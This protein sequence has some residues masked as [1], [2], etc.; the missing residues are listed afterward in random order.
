MTLL[1]L[2][3]VSAALGEAAYGLAGVAA[4]FFFVAAVGSGVKWWGRLNFRTSVSHEEIEVR[5]Y[6]TR[7]IPWAEVKGF[8]IVEYSRVASVPS[9]RN[10]TFGGG[11][12]EACVKI[13]RHKGRSMALPAPLVTRG[14]GDSE[15]DNKVRALRDAH[16]AYRRSLERPPTQQG[17]DRHVQPPTA[18]S[19]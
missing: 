18:V 2:S 8:Q 13:V 16:A 11:K 9:R 19:R 10:A 14:T 4:V 15:F 1:V 6:F 12:K 3:V 17:V 7:R 5:G